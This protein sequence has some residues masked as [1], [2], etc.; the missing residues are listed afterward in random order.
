MADFEVFVDDN[1]HYMDEESRYR[2]GSFAS[3]SDAVAR[4][5][6][7]VD[8]FL[9]E[10]HC[11]GMTSEE[12]YALYTGFGEDPF[13]VPAGE[14]F[15]SA[16]DYARARCK[17]ICREEDE[18]TSILRYSEWPPELKGFSAVL[19]ACLGRNDLAAGVHKT[20]DAF[21][22]AVEHYPDSMPGER[23][24]YWLRLEREGTAYTVYLH[25][26]RFEIHAA[27]TLLEEV[28]WVVRFHGSGRRDLR[29]GDGCA[30]LEGMRVAALAPDFIL[31]ASGG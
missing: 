28:Q 5:K 6:A 20:L 23:S 11:L 30:A 14:P 1:Y 10:S 8:E 3:Y 13:I 19:A 24:W 29:V 16:W 18:V 27:G 15:F 22:R 17:E 25:P 4:S 21:R 2:L 7:I 26:G 9:K 31:K 12:L